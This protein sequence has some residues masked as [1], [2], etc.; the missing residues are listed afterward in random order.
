M[1]PGVGTMNLQSMLMES[2]VEARG[3]LRAELGRLEAQFARV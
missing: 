3:H 2:E 1:T